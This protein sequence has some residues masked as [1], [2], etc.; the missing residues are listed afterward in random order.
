MLSEPYNLGLKDCRRVMSNM[1]PSGLRREGWPEA[2]ISF[3]PKELITTVIW[4]W[5]RNSR[6][7]YLES[8]RF[9][10]SSRRKHPI[11]SQTTSETVASFLIINI[12]GPCS[13]N[14]E[15]K[16]PSRVQVSY[17]KEEEMLFLRKKSFSI[18]LSWSILLTVGENLGEN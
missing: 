18:G 6:E 15:I 13:P 1:L 8:H 7:N 14:T 4:R 17:Q 10:W 3:T 11:P 5:R 12:R 2:S 9:G 16:W